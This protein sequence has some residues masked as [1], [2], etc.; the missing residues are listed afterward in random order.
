MKVLLIQA[1][2]GRRQD[3]TFPVGLACLATAL[4]KHETVVFDPNTV[5][6]PFHEM[7]KV[8][9]KTCPDVIGVSLRNIDTTQSWDIFSYFEAFARAIKK[10]RDVEPY[11]KIIVGGPGFSMFAKEI[12]K[13]MPEIDYGIFLEGENRFPELLENLEHPERV[14]CVYLRREKEVFFTGLSKLL[15][16]DK[17]P[18]PKKELPG[19]N[20]KKY[21]EASYS[22]GVQTK[23][24]CVF[25]CAY[26]T[27]PF[28]QGKFVRSRS[29]KNVVHE[30]EQ[31][32]NHYGI[33]EF[34]FA[35]TVFNFPPDHSRQ[36]CRELMKR[37]LEVKWKA[38][39]REDCMNKASMVEAQRAGCQVFEFSPDGGSQEALDV[40][41][42][43]MAVR[44]IVRVYEIASQIEEIEI[45]FNFMY[46]VP[47]EN[48]RTMASMLKLL[49]GITA[50]CKEKVK[51]LGLSKIRIYPHTRIHRIALRQKVVSQED[52][53]LSPTFYNPFPLNI[54][55]SFALSTFDRR[56]ILSLI[57]PRTLQRRLQKLHG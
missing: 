27:Y 25:D 4:E 2:L 10:I 56:N 22:M 45:A 24:G 48:P 33:D 29:P 47:G 6:Q 32:R 1:P 36:I 38:W 51:W 50:K 23:R 7:K 20:L 15:D 35:D 53:L 39:F 8:I 52:D 14:P 18:P 5:E 30:I 17:L 40:L 11:A 42:K 9:E 16:F 13:R 26:C 43:G 37:K 44:D 21:K 28:I 41:Q 12:M 3:L 54:F 55:Y 34:F 31:T 46:N 57:S 19:L 49:I